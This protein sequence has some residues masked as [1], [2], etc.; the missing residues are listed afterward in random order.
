MAEF[1]KTV[2]TTKQVPVHL[3]RFKW[4]DPIK[5]GSALSILPCT[6]C[7]K[8]VGHKRW[9]IAWAKGDKANYAMR[10]CEKC[11]EVVG[12]KKHLVWLCEKLGPLAYTNP[13]LLIAKSNEIPGKSEKSTPPPQPDKA[14]QPSNFMRIL[15][16]ECKCKVNIRL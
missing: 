11:G 3:L 5:E 2:N 15:C 10:L 6:A 4:Y 12:T 7:R 9:G 14:V 1:T 13:S 16:P 8:R